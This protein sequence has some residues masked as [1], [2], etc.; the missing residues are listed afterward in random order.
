MVITL[1]RVAHGPTLNHRKMFVDATAED[2]TRHNSVI[3]NTSLTRPPYLYADLMAIQKQ[4]QR[5]ANEKHKT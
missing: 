5:F 2:K 1:G 4:K 3:R